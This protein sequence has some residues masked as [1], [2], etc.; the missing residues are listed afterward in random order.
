[1]NI[2]ARVSVSATGTEA[3]GSSNYPYISADGGYV[4][5][6]SDADNLVSTPADLGD[7]GRRHVYRAPVVMP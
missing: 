4:V 7:P 3:N 5:F 1:M 6:D 2:T